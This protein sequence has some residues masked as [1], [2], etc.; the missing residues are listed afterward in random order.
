MKLKVFLGEYMPEAPSVLGFSL[1][2]EKLTNKISWP[3]ATEDAPV[4]DGTKKPEPF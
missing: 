1:K 3:G 2:M 4:H